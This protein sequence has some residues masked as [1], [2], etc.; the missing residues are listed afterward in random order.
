MAFDHLQKL[1]QKAQNSDKNAV[2]EGMV[3]QTNQRLD[4]VKR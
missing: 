3:T 1:I 4:Q 2:I